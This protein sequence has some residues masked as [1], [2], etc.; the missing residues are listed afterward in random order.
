MA[1]R[2]CL[3]FISF[4]V[5]QNSFPRIIMLRFSSYLRNLAAPDVSWKISQGVTG[6]GLEWTRA[7][8]KI[9]VS[10][11]Y[12]DSKARHA[13]TTMC[14]YLRSIGV[15]VVLDCNDPDLKS[16]NGEYKTSSCDLVA[17]N[18]DLVVCLGG[19]G[20]VLRTVGWL[21][22]CASPSQIPPIMAFGVGTLGFLSPFS[23]AEYASIF[24]RILDPPNSYPV[25]LRSRLKCEVFQEPSVPGI[26]RRVLN[27]CLVARGSH[28]AFQHLDCTIDGMRV[29]QFQA[30]G[31]IIAT[32]SGSSAYSMAAGGSLVAPTVPSIL[33]TPVAPHALSARPLI[34]PSS[35][36]IEVHVPKHARSR[37]I[38][39]FDG[40]NELV[41]E[42]NAV[43]KVSESKTKVPFLCLPGSTGPN[44]DWFVSLRS[45]LH[46]AK[47]VRRPT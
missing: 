46:W 37:P 47:E 18:V 32:P 3:V 29:A 7:P 31:L 42:R 12:N 27:E 25:M 10:K 9:L 17:E 14:E 2:C 24:A 35:S 23:V 20:T 1:V 44:S 15:E 19:D 4:R 11:K 33:L 8:K 30:D 38:V 40:H 26:V 5:I 28:S 34:L 39:S 16:S 22:D 36:V 13:M 6:S 45:K 43:I 41:L 21:G